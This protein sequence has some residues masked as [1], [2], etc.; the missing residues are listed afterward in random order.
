VSERQEVERRYRAEAERMQNRLSEIDV[1]VHQVAWQ[2]EPRRGDLEAES[3][4]RSTPTGGSARSLAESDMVFLA[5]QG[6]ESRIEHEPGTLHER[7]YARSQWDRSYRSGDGFRVFAQGVLEPLDVAILILRQDGWT[8]PSHYFGHEEYFRGSITEE[9]S[10]AWSHE[11]FETLGWD[12]SVGR[13]GRAMTVERMQQIYAQRGPLKP[14][15][16]L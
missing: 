4:F 10:R 11:S 6:F 2:A 16:L 15:W 1:L 3:S 7:P 8:Y 14:S 5:S 12:R 9:Q 13:D